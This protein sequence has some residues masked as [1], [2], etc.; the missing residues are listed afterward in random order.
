MGIISTEGE[1][2]GRIVQTGGTKSEGME[3]VST[4]CIRKWK[5][6]GKGM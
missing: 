2:G 1:V 4:G 3:I 5:S 6:S